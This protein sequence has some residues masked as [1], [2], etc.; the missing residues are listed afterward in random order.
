MKDKELILEILANLT[1]L[2]KLE[3]IPRKER[4][5]VYC[6]IEWLLNE[7]M[8]EKKYVKNKKDE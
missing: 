3:D 2:K 6:L 4:E 7:L 5:A 1:V 8:D